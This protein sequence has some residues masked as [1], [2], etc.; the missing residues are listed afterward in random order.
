MRARITAALQQNPEAVRR[1][2]LRWVE[3]GEGEA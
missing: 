3:A 1:L 2:F